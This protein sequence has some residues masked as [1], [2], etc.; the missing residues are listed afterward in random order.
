MSK[1]E[2]PPEL[3]SIATAPALPAVP[4]VLVVG[5]KPISGEAI[6]QTW[7]P[8]GG[9]TILDLYFGATLRAA[10]ELGGF[11]VQ[12]IPSDEE[13]DAVTELAWRLAISAVRTRPDTRAVPSG[14]PQGGL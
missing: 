1:L 7:N 12:I 8:M 13:L 2:V 4:A 10:V 14:L 3:H 9:H 11:D 5:K 6:V